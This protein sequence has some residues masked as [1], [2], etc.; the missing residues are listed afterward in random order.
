MGSTDRSSVERT[1]AELEGDARNARAS[2]RNL[3]GAAVGS[4]CGICRRLDTDHIGNTV[5]GCSNTSQLPDDG[6]R[7][8]LNLVIESAFDTVNRL[9][10][11]VR[12]T[13][14]LSAMHAQID[15]LNQ[16]INQA[17]ERYSDLKDECSSL[18][19]DDVLQNRIT[20]VQEGVTQEWCD[21]VEGKISKDLLLRNLEDKFDI[22]INDDIIANFPS[23]ATHP[24]IIATPT[25]TPTLPLVGTGTGTATGTATGTGTGTGTAAG[26]GAASGPLGPPIAAPALIA[27]CSY[28]TGGA[29]SGD[30]IGKS[31]K[32]ITVRFSKNDFA[33][34]HIQKESSLLNEV[35]LIYPNSTLATTISVF[36]SHCDAATK[37]IAISVRDAAT[38]PFGSIN[39]YLTAFR[40][41]RYPTFHDD[42]RLAFNELKQTQNESAIQFYFRFEY[43]LKVMSRNVEDYRDDFFRKLVHNRVR[44]AVRLFPKEGKSI[45]DLAG[46]AT[47]VENELG[48]RR[49]V[50]GKDKNVSSCDVNEVKKGG[51]KGGKGGGKGGKGGNSGGS[52]SNGQRGR[53]QSRNRSGVFDQL[54]EWG[55]AKNACFHCFDESHSAKDGPCAESACVFCAKTGHQSIRCDKAPKTKEEFRK[56]VKSD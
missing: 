34:I 29:P 2:L 47:M 38:V 8:N 44:D 17:N 5:T 50:Y 20:K 11:M 36:I 13:D 31:A 42:C 9:K 22:V 6:Y 40:L 18:I 33:H 55:L 24:P 52:G 12:T 54:G 21:F 48:L 39:D 15:D 16:R 28:A 25:T 56:I 46:H 4:I 32:T 43:L 1:L 51:K 49:T 41:A 3:A 10:S 7:Q 37:D 19:T 23:R 30:I 14:Q 35:D 27:S 45:R 26:A 53:S